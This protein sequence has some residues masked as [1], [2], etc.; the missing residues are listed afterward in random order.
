M[1]DAVAGGHQSS[2]LPEIHSHPRSLVWP[3]GR[4]ARGGKEEGGVMIT[5]VTMDDE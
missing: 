2:S 4:S 5:D 3:E 1:S